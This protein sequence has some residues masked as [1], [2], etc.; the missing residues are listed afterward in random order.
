MT[1]KTC[2]VCTRT[3]DLSQFHVDKEGRPRGQCRQCAA[4]DCARRR[5]QKAHVLVHRTDPMNTILRQWRG[6]V[7]RG[8]MTWVV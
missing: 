3:L 2:R 6:P 1:T 8:A 5:K 7:T 4:A